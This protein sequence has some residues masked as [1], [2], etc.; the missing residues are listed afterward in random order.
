MANKCVPVQ[1]YITQF[2]VFQLQ[3]PPKEINLLRHTRR[4]G[5]LGEARYGI[6]GGT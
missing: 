5:A 6:A 3:A 2:S 1:M 4:E